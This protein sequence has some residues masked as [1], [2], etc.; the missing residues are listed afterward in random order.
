MMVSEESLIVGFPIKDCTISGKKAKWQ[1]LRKT[2]REEEGER[3]REWE[4]MGTLMI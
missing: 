3:V 2:V 4:V 1:F